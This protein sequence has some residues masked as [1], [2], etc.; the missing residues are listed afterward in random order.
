MHDHRYTLAHILTAKYWQRVEKGGV[1]LTVADTGWAK[2]SWG[3]IYGQWL[4]GSVVMV[5]D[6]DVFDPRQLVAI[7]NQYGVTSFC[8]PP[9]VYRY[10]V[11]RGTLNFETLRYA[12]S[13]GESLP[14]E[15]ARLF[16]E[17]TGLCIAEGYGQTE[18]TLSVAN[19]AGMPSRRG[20]IGKPTPL[21]DVKIVRPDGT[22]TDVDEPGEIVI[23][24]RENQ[25]GLMIG[26]I[27]ENLSII[28]D[29]RRGIFPTGDIARRDAD[30]YYW[31]ISR[32][33][34][35]IKTG[36]F[37]VGPVEI[38]HVLQEH[39]QVLDCSVVGVP[40][41]M[42]GQAIQA[43]VVLSPDTDPSPELENEIKTYCNDR[44]AVYKHIRRIVFVKELPKTFNGKS[45]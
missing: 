20:S 13:A 32:A 30:G 42:R 1:H 14:P 5:Y 44:L 17:H 9:T 19:I 31:Y 28:N 2:A 8:A 3:K 27:G 34:D 21:Y 24:P 22:E 41:P 12:C 40:D 6:N 29:A 18:M 10:M 33:D 7:M 26:Y 37:R 16:E 11:K 38:E 43:M 39:P 36:G 4:L 35:M 15:I 25:F 45:K 23:L